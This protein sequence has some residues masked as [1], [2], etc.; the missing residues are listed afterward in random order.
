MGIETARDVG[1]SGI[2]VAYERFGGA[3]GAPVLLIMGLA[4]QMLGWPDGFCEMLAGRG[5]G[6]IR[7]D[8]RDVGLST[9]LHDAPRA[10]VMAAA[11]GD[12]S[13]ASYVLADM[14]ADTV[15]LLDALELD[16]A[17]IVGASMGGMIAQIV[18]TDYPERV[19]SLTSIMSTTGNTSVGRPTQAAM[20]ALLTP[21]AKTR[22]QAM[23]RAVQ[24]FRVVGSPGFELDVDELR[25][26]TG[27]AFDR[28]Y[29]PQGIARQMLAVVASPD[30]TAALR[31][32]SAPTLVLHGADDALVD[33]SGARATAE[34]IPGAELVIIDGMGHD[35]PQPLWPQITERFA[36]LVARADSVVSS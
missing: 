14:A 5:L 1:P 24:V 21:P 35:L 32:V 11:Q 6:V 34:A 26:R 9:H 2:E 4:T 30:R 12:T 23:D 22:E 16:S 33:V 18:A 3:D 36:E 28:A 15:G 7:F 8:N 17:H 29:D 13:S 27:R 20:G 19:R 31:S 25:D 10:D